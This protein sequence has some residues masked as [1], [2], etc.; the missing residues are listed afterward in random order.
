[1]I[2]DGIFVKYNEQLEMSPKDR[3]NFYK[4]AYFHGLDE[5][6]KILMRTSIL[7]AGL[8]VVISVY[9]EA[10]KS[11]LLDVLPIEVKYVVIMMAVIL[12]SLSLV[13]CFLTLLR[14][15]Y[16]HFNSEKVESEYIPKDIPNF[17]NARSRYNNIVERSDKIHS[18]TTEGT[19]VLEYF[20]KNLV[21]AIT[22][23]QSINEKRRKWFHYSL[24][25]ILTNLIL[26]ILVMVTIQV[27][28]PYMSD[29]E[30]KTEEVKNEVPEPPKGPELG[31]SKYTRED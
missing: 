18:K 19:L 29:T 13:F 9:L 10:L 16:N 23:N 12:L 7:L 6:N 2:F 21:D 20:I 22:H 30:E 3:Y 1:M 4:N 15:S 14:R 17:L 11:K 8:A 26:I 27:G 25:S 24:Y 28:V 5:P 31:T